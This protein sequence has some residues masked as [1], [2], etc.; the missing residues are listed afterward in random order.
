MAENNTGH[1]LAT[2]VASALVLLPL[3]VAAVYFGGWAFFALVLVS[4]VLMAYEWE[5][6]RDERGLPSAV[7]V[8]AVAVASLVV[9]ASGAPAVAIAVLAGGAV[10]AYVALGFA[11]RRAGW[12]A[13]GMLYVGLPSLALLWLRDDA[14]FGRDGLYWLFCV[15][16]ATDIGAY[17]AGRAIGGPKLAPRISPKKTWAGLAGGVIAAGASGAAVALVAG[18]GD[19]FWL[20]V[21]GSALAL[22][23]Q[24]GDLVESA[25]KRHFDRKD[26]GSLIPGHGGILD[27]VDG[28]VFAAPVVALFMMLFVERST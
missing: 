1:G 24:A 19:P 18:F 20:F 4:V 26:S 5:M 25:I 7:A 2:R 10:A 3:A 6:M 8:G 28:L 27:R 21:A 17:A 23:A 12:V 15:V 9:M 11:R 16:W 22:V 14:G 13:G